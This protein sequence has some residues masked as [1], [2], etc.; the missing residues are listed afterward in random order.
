[1]DASHALSDD[2]L[3]K[4]VSFDARCGAGVEPYLVSDE[5]APAV[6]AFLSA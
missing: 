3:A 1:M 6:P 5:D 4:P 2:G